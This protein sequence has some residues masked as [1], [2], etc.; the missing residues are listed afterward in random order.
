VEG[1]EQALDLISVHD[2]THLG[3]IST[4]PLRV[5]AANLPYVGARDTELQL[6]V[7]VRTGQAAA[8]RGG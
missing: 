4:A 3:L 7:I 2:A 8:S 6:R 5:I 1:I